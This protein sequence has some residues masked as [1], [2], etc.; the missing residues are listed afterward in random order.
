MFPITLTAAFA[1]LLGLYWMRTYYRGRL[2]ATPGR[3]ASCDYSLDD[4]DRS[5]CPECGTTGRSL[6]G[7]DP[8]TLRR[9]A[10]RGAWL[11]MIA[12]PIAFMSMAPHNLIAQ[13]YPTP[14]A[15]A[16]CG[17]K[18]DWLGSL[19]AT[20]ESRSLTPD[21]NATIGIRAV[22]TLESGLFFWQLQVPGLLSMCWM[23]VVP[24]AMASAH[25]RGVDEPRIVAALA[26]AGSRGT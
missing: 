14:V 10:N 9:N 11:F 19:D 12:A 4:L 8:P 26:R 5:L 16:L 22:R 15:V 7:G 6:Q 3:C 1:A 20:V 21:Q 18:L 13:L 17:T 25:A 2:K 24:K 23:R